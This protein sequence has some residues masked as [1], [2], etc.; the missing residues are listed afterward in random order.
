MIGAERLHEGALVGSAGRADHRAA[1]VL[2]D[3]DHGGADG[4]S[5]ARYEDDVA[6]LQLRDAQEAC[7]GGQAGHASNA[8]EGALGQADVRQFLHHGGL[9]LCH[10]GGT[11]AQHGGHKIAGLV[12][13]M[14]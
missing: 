8:E 5:R 9:G 4:A 13:R 3:L 6:F 2:G 7:I 12:V 14:R 11:P 10:P 1:L